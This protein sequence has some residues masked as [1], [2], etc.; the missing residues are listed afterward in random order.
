MFASQPAKPQPVA[1]ARPLRSVFLRRLLLAYLLFVAVVTGVQLYLAYRTIRAEIAVTLN[2]LATATAPSA[3]TAL[4]DI[5]TP[6]LD[7]MVAGLMAHPMVRYV[8]VQDDVGRILGR[9]G[10]APP[11]GLDDAQLLV[12]QTLWH[13]SVGAAPQAIGTLLIASQR[14]VALSMLASVGQAEVASVAVQLVF[15]ALLLLLLVQRLV[16]APLTL[17]S[18][19]VGALT[20]HRADEPIDLGRVETRE[21]ATL[22]HGF[23]RLLAQIAQSHAVIARQNL[24]LEQRVQ[25]RTR[26]LNEN[27]AQLGKIF[28]HAHNGI[29]FADGFG[30]LMR[31]N[32]RLCEMLGY[33]ALALPVANFLKLSHPQDLAAEEQALWAMRNGS[34]TDYQLEKR[35]LDRTGE[36]VWVDVAVSAIREQGGDTVNVVGVVVDVSER[37]RIA[38]A[39]LEAKDRA[40]EATRAKSDF[41]ANMS[42]EIR[43]PMNTIIGM[44][45]LA[46]RAD[47]NPR[48]RNYVEKVHRSAV[49]LLGILNDI[50][51]FSKIEAGKLSLENI[52][53]DLDEVMDQLASLLATK[54]SE[55]AVELHFR[56]A[57]GIPNALVGDPL[58]LGQVL[59]NLAGNAVKF[60]AQGDI[61]VGLE[62]GAQHGQELELHFWVQDSGIGMT[63]EQ[64]ER[65]FQSF[66]QADAST[67]RK[68]GGTGL[69]LVISKNLVE[70]MGGRVWVQSTPGV[71]S[72]F[73]FTVRVGLQTGAQVRRMFL[74]D[75][76]AGTRVLVVDDNPIARDILAEMLDSFGMA[77]HTAHSSDDALRQLHDAVHTRLRFDLV[78]MDWRMPGC[79]G[80]QCLSAIQRAYGAHPPCV[81]VTGYGREDAEQRAQ[82][83]GVL[84]AGILLKPTTPSNL[85]EAVGS[86]LNPQGVEAAAKPLSLQTPVD[87]QQQLNGARVLLVEDNLMN[88]EL[89]TELLQQAGMVVV[90][91]ENGQHALDILASAPAFDGVLMDCQMPVMDGY[92]ATRLLRQDPRWASLPVIA[93]T[94]N[95]MAGERERVLQ[96]G[97]NDHISKP[98]VV[99]EMFNTIARWMHA[100]QA[101]DTPG[102]HAAQLPAPT[103]AQSPAP[104]SALAPPDA[105]ALADPQ[106][107]AHAAGAG[108]DAALGLLR[109]NGDPVLYQKML[110]RF[111]QGHADFGAQFARALAHADPQDAAA[112]RLAH[113]LMGSAGT[114]GA[115]TLQRLAQGLESACRDGLAPQ[116]LAPLLQDVVQALQTVLHGLETVEKAQFS[117]LK[118]VAATHAERPD[119]ALP[120]PVPVPVHT[121]PRDELQRTLQALAQ[122]IARYDVEALDLSQALQAGVPQTALQPALRALELALQSFDFDA[123]ATHL[124]QLNRALEAL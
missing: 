39:M 121:L 91:A 48:Q 50:L 120:V 84:L 112:Q 52:P 64:S 33:P 87:I 66:S 17:F 77:V 11:E 2:F 118:T 9:K 54:L 73:H 51:D 107:T 47:L 115:T 22:E 5:E 30:R 76:L 75:E 36:P 43:T 81:L 65:L 4:W 71:G 32:T 40:E 56:Q 38:Q 15:L 55:R 123:A 63:P 62:P 122:C 92:T 105:L 110:L 124:E 53:F 31:Y 37:R 74:A 16:V 70:L 24:E 102:E 79:D 69:G 35:Y 10:E 97:M 14:S 67:T 23:N 119:N 83:Q 45:H 88:Q 78:L 1:S 101:G 28:E 103:P 44:S 59:L 113:T 68:F 108:I 18:A 12:R 42:H 106:W 93:M 19:K 58:R 29:F 99:Q 82:Q 3:E 98:L 72:V 95:A 27:Q 89:A 60:T 86:A 85:L 25:E 80:L 90:I 7:S 34:V 6:L 94:A 49:N 26:A 100:R 46:L 8:V 109:A 114:I 57:P 13:H 111:R 104:A 61:V 117:G 21:I 20:V 96:A 41:L 116:Q